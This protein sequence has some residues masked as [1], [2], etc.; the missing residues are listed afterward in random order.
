MLVDA[1]NKWHKLEKLLR[2]P[3]LFKNFSV[4]PPRGVL[5]FGPSGKILN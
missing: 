5:L 3:V 1:E 4:K 2:H